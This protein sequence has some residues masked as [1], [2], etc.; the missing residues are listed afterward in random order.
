MIELFW[1]KYLE[2]ISLLEKSQQF[3]KEPREATKKNI[4]VAGPRTRVFLNS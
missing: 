3:L 1:M 4:T 2:V